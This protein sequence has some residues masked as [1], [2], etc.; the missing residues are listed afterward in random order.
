[1]PSIVTIVFV[2][3][4]TFNKISLKVAQNYISSLRTMANWY[5]IEHSA[6]SHNSVYLLLLRSFKINST[7]TPTPKAI[8][9]LDTLDPDPQLFRSCFLLVFFGLMRMSNIAS[10]SSTAFDTSKHLLRQDI[11]FYSPSMHIRVKWTKTLQ[12]HSQVH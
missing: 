2:V 1:M 12:D 11:I 4:L 9:T 6:L 3:Y 10:H 7:F 8:F 5:T